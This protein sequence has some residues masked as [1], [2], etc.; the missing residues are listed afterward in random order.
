MSGPSSSVLPRG[1]TEQYRLIE[2]QATSNHGC[3]Y[4]FRVFEPKQPQT[5]THVVLGHGFL[6]N[7]DRL[8]G[9]SLAL[10]NA[11]IPVATLDFCNMRPWNGH[12]VRNAADMRALAARLGT[13]N[14]VIYAGFSAGAL[15][16]VLAADKQ[17]RAVV[18]FDLVDSDNMAVDAIRLLDI[19]LLGLQGAPSGCN[20]H[21]MGEQVF[22]AREFAK[23]GADDTAN[24]E[25]PLSLSIPIPDASH[26]D[27]ESPTNW[28][29]EAACGDKKTDAQKE[30]KRQQIISETLRLIEPYLL[31][32]VKPVVLPQD[33]VSS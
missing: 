3:Q 16:A 26:C 14:N 21:N 30:D 13:E 33:T 1:S 18:T 9:M 5:S 31:R 25:R 29:C 10:A 22:K 17:T 11:G 8:V 24:Y 2:G 19:P 23:Q 12:H 4:A 6:R 28:L 15:A 20:A 27:F 7:Q 32:F